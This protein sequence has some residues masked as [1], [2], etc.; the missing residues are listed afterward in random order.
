MPI[1]E[2][3]IKLDVV[4]DFTWDSRVQSEKNTVQVLEE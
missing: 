3:L 1:L 4:K 2:E